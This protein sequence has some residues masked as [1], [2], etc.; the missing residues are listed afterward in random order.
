MIGKLNGV[1][2]AQTPSGWRKE[3]RSTSVETWSENSPLVSSAIPQANSTTSMPADD[4]A[5]GVLERLAVLGG[6]DPRE[7]VRVLHD[8]LAEG[9]HHPRAAADR[10][11]AP[12]LEGGLG[13]LHGGVDVGGL[14]EQDLGAARWPVAGS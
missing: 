4:L 2:P 11:V 13:G 6:D 12:A 10:R 5:L 7:L 1:I 9:E 8:Q 3:C 14:G